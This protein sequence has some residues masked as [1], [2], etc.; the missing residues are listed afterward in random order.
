ML[1]GG[2]DGGESDVS[3]EKRVDEAMHCLDNTEVPLELRPCN[4]VDDV[5]VA[6]WLRKGGCGCK[7]Q[8]YL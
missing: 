1:N 4:I 5:L 7:R 3:T 8:C 6:D 2:S